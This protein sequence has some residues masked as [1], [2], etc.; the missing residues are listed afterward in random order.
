VTPLDEARHALRHT[1]RRG[2]FA[3]LLDQREAHL[4]LSAGELDRAA[5]LI[6]ELDSG[7]DRSVLAAL[8]LAARGVPERGLDLLD[9]VPVADAPLSARCTV[10]LASLACALEAGRPWEP[11]AHSVI[12]LTESGGQVFAVAEAGSAVLEAVCA[13]ARRLPQT[14][15]LRTLMLTRPHAPRS[16]QPV[17]DLAADALSERERVVLRYL[18]TAMSYREIADELYVS[19]NTVKTHVKNI[20]RKLQAESRVAAIRRARELRYL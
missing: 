8:L 19:V 16:G 12:E 10:A 15:H 20:N 6:D 18:V 1:P 4:L 14:D 2:R 9:A 7:L 11:L 5:E 3:Q 17:I 13:V